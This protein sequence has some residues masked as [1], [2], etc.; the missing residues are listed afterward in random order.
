MLKKFFP[1]HQN[2]LKT[3]AL[4]FAGLLAFTALAANFEVGTF[5]ITL[6]TGILRAMLLFLVA[7]GLS[8]I[9]GLMDIL[10]FAQ[11]GIF[12]LGA[13]ITYNVVHPAVGII[14]FG[15]AIEDVTMRFAVALAFATAVGAAVGYL[16]ERFLL[17][18]LYKRALFQLVLTFG[19]SIIVLEVIKSIWGPSPYSWT[20]RLPIQESQFFIFGAQ[21]STY[22]LFV[23][24]IGLVLM[25]LVVLLL[26]R[27]RIG[28]I[29]RAGVQ[30]PEMVSALGI[31]VRGVFTLVF[32]LGCALAA[33]GGGIAVPFLG[34]TNTLGSTFLLAGIAV[35]V[36]GGL[37]SFEGTAV[38][39]FIVGIGW[40]AMEQFSARPGIGTVWA[41]MAPMLLLA[42][43]LLLRPKGLF[44]EDR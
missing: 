30:D 29:I 1:A 37:G 8:L 18:P 42:L 24:G 34:A 40:A 16:L 38:G 4:I 26:R 14:R 19:T 31:N 17:R 3:T 35:I 10:N 36:L 5:S 12:M 39:S 33:F 44:G 41:S 2:S 28:I 27:T 13:Y 7:A 11:G 20:V 21:F 15:G 6:L 23:I 9:F 43:V 32:T 22:R 25:A